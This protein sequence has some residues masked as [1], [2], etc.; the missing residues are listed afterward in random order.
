MIHVAFEIISAASA[1]DPTKK[2]HPYLDTFAS[3][4]GNYLDSLAPI[5]IIV[6]NEN[7]VSIF[8]SK[9]NIK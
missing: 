5:V 7:I 9:P 4:V 2:N 8:M 1:F 3:N 6:L